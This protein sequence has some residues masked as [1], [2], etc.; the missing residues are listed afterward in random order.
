M[1]RGIRWREGLKSRSN[2]L[3]DSG[4]IKPEFRCRG[5]FLSK[6][7]MSTDFMALTWA[8]LGMADVNGVRTAARILSDAIKTVSSSLTERTY[9]EL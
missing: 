5:A 4:G 8:I 7:D 1:S 6:T 3:L 2:R 9:A